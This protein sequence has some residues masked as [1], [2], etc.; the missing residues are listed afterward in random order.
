MI[1][2]LQALTEL[3]HRMA[4]APVGPARELR[5]TRVGEHW[6]CDEARRLQQDG[7][8]VFHT[9]DNIG[10]VGGLTLRGL[11]LLAAAGVSLP[12]RLP[13][14]PHIDGGYLTPWLNP[15]AP[16]QAPRQVQLQLALYPP[17]RR[18]LRRRAA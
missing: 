5:V 13:G 16:V 6:A 14:R 8:A 17:G 4:Y 15:P 9:L 18:I 3:A 1:S 10:R 7:L 11:A 12:P 2:R